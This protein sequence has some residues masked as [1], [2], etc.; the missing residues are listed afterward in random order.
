[1]PAGYVTEGDDE[2]LVSVGDKI[3]DK[4][5]MENLVLF[6]L[7]LDEMIDR[8]VE[9]SVRFGQDLGQRIS[10]AVQKAIDGKFRFRRQEKNPQVQDEE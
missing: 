10:D 5:E 2:I 9:D 1:M 4:G 7:E 3:A 8:Q 6:D